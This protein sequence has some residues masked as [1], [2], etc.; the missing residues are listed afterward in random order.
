MAFE[1]STAV[2]S[3]TPTLDFGSPAAGDWLLVWFIATES[4]NIVEGLPSGEGWQAL[5]DNG[6]GTEVSGVT[7]KFVWV[8]KQWGVGHT[9]DSTPSFTLGGSSGV[10]YGLRIS[11]GG[12]IGTPVVSAVMGTG[13]SPSVDVPDDGSQV[14]FA[15]ANWY[16][17]QAPTGPTQG[18][19]VGAHDLDG[20]NFRVGASVVAKDAGA[21][22][23]CGW[24]GT[25]T[26]QIRFSLVLP[27]AITYTAE[28]E[29]Y[30]WR[31]DDGSESAATWRQ[32]QDTADSVAPET[33]VRLRVL[34][35]YT[36]DP[37]SVAHTLQVRRVG[38]SDSTW[39]TIG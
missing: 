5:L 1:S 3:T 13:T 35:N 29:G 28:A 21:S 18:S 7:R 22:G 37:G 9:D 10:A 32:S 16:G 8:G 12:A 6:S 4:P 34:V 11:G 27:P 26:E 38:D 24:T 15:A 23:T 36:G 17:A 14:V 20:T 25:A 33:T 31:N 2:L 30:R 19:L 39:E